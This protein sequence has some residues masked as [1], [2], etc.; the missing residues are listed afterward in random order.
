M[1][2][3]EL[4][5]VASQQAA[6]LDEKTGGVTVDVMPYD[7]MTQEKEAPTGF[8]GFIDSFK[9][10]DAEDLGLDPNL[11]DVE[12][13]AI[14]TANSPLSRSL[15]NRHLQ[16]I[17]IG[18]AIGTGLFVGSGKRLHT[19]GPAGV[20]IGYTLIGTL[21]YVTCQALGELAVTFPV[22]GAFVTYNTRFID[23]SWGF[24]MAWNYAM[25]MY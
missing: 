8:A 20:L 25:G 5:Y 4:N 11:T 14:I 17:A 9:R 15:K 6:S 18:G 3:K 12:R 1:P 2:E 19:G 16:M 21:V 23:P 10:Y 24:A 13:T 22:S 7:G